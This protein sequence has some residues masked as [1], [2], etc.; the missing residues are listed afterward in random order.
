MTY[1]GVAFGYHTPMPVLSETK[2]DPE[3]HTPVSS[4]T[5]QPESLA[6][7]LEALLLSN[8]RPSPA[9]KLAEALGV[10][11]GRVIEEAEV[12]S[13]I[14]QLN[15]A[16]EATGRA[17]RVD[18][19][20]GGY[21]VMTREAFADVVAA[22]HRSSSS[23]RLSRAALETLALVA[24]RQPLTRA[25]LEAIRGVAT[26]EVL[27]S[28]IDRGLVKVS[29]RAEEPGR[30]LLY[31]TTKRFLDV[32]GLASLKDLPKPGE[33]GLVMPA[34]SEPEAT[35][36]PGAADTK[37]PD[38]EPTAAMQDQTEPSPPASQGHDA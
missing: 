32:F 11:A 20:A 18:Q 38:T 24:Y 26:G 30:P 21:R 16:Y 1:P 33:L 5:T 4:K 8:D 31:A 37:R 9:G 10:H 29:G 13:L 23:G 15:E 3:P 14:E 35:Q 12:V 7:A 28:L 17:F 27:R 2:P 22:F 6:G 34:P 25:E 36:G 19:V